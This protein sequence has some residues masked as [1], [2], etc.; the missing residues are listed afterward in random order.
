MEKI[1]K[2]FFN[3]SVHPVF[4]VVNKKYLEAVQHVIYLRTNL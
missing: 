3:S 4:S 2:Y 1:K